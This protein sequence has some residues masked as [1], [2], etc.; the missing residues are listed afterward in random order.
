MLAEKELIQL[1]FLQNECPSKVCTFW[2][3]QLFDH[4][5]FHWEEEVDGGMKLVELMENINKGVEETKHLINAKELGKNSV[6]GFNEFTI[7]NANAMSPHHIPKIKG[8]RGEWA[9][10]QEKRTA[11]KKKKKDWAIYDEVFLISHTLDKSI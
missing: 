7:N 8:L 6:V 9:M 1:K 10:K 2:L 11:T 5:Y 3:Y 4:L